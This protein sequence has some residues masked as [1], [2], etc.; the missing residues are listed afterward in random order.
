MKTADLVRYN[1]AVSELYFDALNK[2]PWA[3]VIKPRGISFDSIRN[4]FLHLMFVEDR[5]ISYTL[6]NR[7]TLWKDPSFE[8]Y[9][10]MALIEEYMTKVKENTEE[11]LQNLEPEDWARK[12][13]NPWIHRPDA[14]ITIETALCHMV[15]EDMIH[16]GE[17]SAVL[18]QLNLDAPYLAFLRYM[19]NQENSKKQL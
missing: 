11:F 5:W 3:E 8:S 9:H 12:V 19:Y 2:L 17:L 10:N 15:L 6:K 7:F 14:A 4:V 18:W 1:I 16:Y 13:P